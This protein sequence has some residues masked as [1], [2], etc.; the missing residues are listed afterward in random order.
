M[1]GWPITRDYY[2]YAIYVLQ[3]MRVKVIGLDIL[4][5]TADNRYPE[6]DNNLTDFFDSF[7]N[8]CLP[9]AFSEVA[10]NKTINGRLY[11]NIL[12]ADSPVFPIIK[13]RKKVAGVGFSNLSNETIPNKVPLIMAYQD[14]LYYSFGFELARLFLEIP[15][16]SIT[17]RKD[18]IELNNSEG[19]QYFLPIDRNGNIYL[20]HFGSIEN[21]N[22]INFL[23]VLHT[24]Q[25]NRDSLNLN[26]KLV[27]IA[28][29]APGYST[30]KTTPLAAA[31]PAVLI[32]VTAA[33]NII[34]QNYLQ[35]VPKS[36]Q[37]LAILIVFASLL[38]ILNF[39]KTWIKITTI[40]MLIVL[41]YL[42]VILLFNQLNYIFPVFYPTLAFIS[43]FI[44][45]LLLRKYQLKQ[46]LY[47]HK[48]L[49]SSQIA[50][51]QMLLD[52]TEQEL[53]TIKE[54]HDQ[55]I[56]NKENLTHDYQHLIKEHKNKIIELEKQITDLQSYVILKDSQQE[57]KAQFPSFIYKEGSK[58]VHVLD[59]IHK[60]SS[61]DIAVIIMGETGTG[62]EL[63]ARTIHNLSRRK[64]NPFV[65]VN[66]G[67]LSE[68]LLESE[69]FGHEKGSFTGALSQRRGRFELADGGTIFLDEITETSPAFQVKLLRTLQERTIERIGSE[70]TIKVDIRV[71]SASS[72][73]FE[74]EIK[75]GRFREDLFYR[76]NGI[77]IVL[78]PL[79]ERKE[80]IPL[81]ATHFL[82][83][84]QYRSITKFSTQAMEY[85][86]QYN[87]PG[88]V[89]EL[90]NV[91]RRCAILAR[92]EGR[93][94]IR[95]ND[96]PHEIQSPSPDSMDY[97]P[98]EIQILELLRSLKFKHTA[99]T[100][101]ARILGNRDRGTITEYFRGSCF[102][103]LVQSKF[104]LDHTVKIIADTNSVEIQKRVKQKLIEYL[105]NLSIN[106]T[107]NIE[108]TESL[109]VHPSFKGLPKKYHND[110]LQI[111][112][113]YIHDMNRYQKI[114]KS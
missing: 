20:N 97:Q 46:E 8:I 10:F 66:C 6:Y 15:A 110:L 91:V 65:A 9:M 108:N 31:I 33:E 76:L 37:V 90:E 26:G 36:Y 87:W 103:H 100:R 16:D 72:K 7:R 27:V 78:P 2:G 51:K 74:A 99:I 30:L 79:R 67:A 62:K 35:I 84:H 42:M 68:T 105:K 96:L 73:N 50:E 81:L 77:T 3:Q 85:L 86:I 92:S 63:S 61:D 59:L 29:T 106:E 57:V 49:F 98:M 109:T 104:N 19:K 113:H 112:K 94:M 41:Y 28:V 107:M 83:K 40:T 56:K 1:Q 114:V 21:I 12:T 53:M 45:N 82:A 64:N 44:I 80:D 43:L 89:R 18:K 75:N 60:V 95:I 13:F 4:F 38:F 111:I 55:E 58:L 69:L 34:E 25:T 24:F 88:N 32:H 54:K 17:L 52:Q 39:R 71:I 48:D 14:S 47:L 11:G 22:H 102:A 70:K 101:I 23:K 5:D 93:N